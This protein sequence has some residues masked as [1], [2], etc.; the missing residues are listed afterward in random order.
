MSSLLLA[1]LSCHSCLKT[2]VIGY[3][4]PAEMAVDTM[5]KKERMMSPKPPTLPKGTTAQDGRVSIGF[6]PTVADWDEKV[7]EL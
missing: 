4:P 7:I 6:N 1:A 2:E 5:A 3:E